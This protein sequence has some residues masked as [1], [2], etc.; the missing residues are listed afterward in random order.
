[1]SI[2][3]KENW[4]TEAVLN[5]SGNSGIGYTGSLAEIPIDPSGT[6]FGTGILYVDQTGGARR[7]CMGRGV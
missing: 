6:N 2:I 4:G 5:L 1:M 7:H 3:R